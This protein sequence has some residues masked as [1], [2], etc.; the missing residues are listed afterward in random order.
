VQADEELT[1]VLREALLSAAQNSDVPLAEGDAMRIARR[2]LMCKVALSQAPSPLKFSARVSTDRGHR[3]L[4]VAVR[5]D[6]GYDDV[7]PLF[8]IAERLLSRGVV[9]LPSPTVFPVVI[10][11]DGLAIVFVVQNDPEENLFNA[12]QG[13]GWALTGLV[14]RGPTFQVE[15][16]RTDFRQ[17]DPRRMLVRRFAGKLVVPPIG[18]ALALREVRRLIRATSDAIGDIELLYLAHIFGVPFEIAARRCEEEKLLPKGG[19][20]AIGD[21]MK[22]ELGGARFRAASAGLPARVAFSLSP[23]P[24]AVIAVIAPGLL[25]GDSASA[26]RDGLGLSLADISAL[27]AMNG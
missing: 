12:A 24:G 22:N 15:I 26:L 7:E 23:L 4:A 5:G 3:E 18:L 16:Q 2:A 1:F 14:D 21:Y 8:D 10:K 6:L 19:A 13:I 25:S 27:E 17:R 11:V 9:L 20:K